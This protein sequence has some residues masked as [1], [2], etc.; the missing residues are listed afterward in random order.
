[1]TS[2]KIQMMHE[3]Y[4]DYVD[5]Q[6]ELGEFNNPSWEEWRKEKYNG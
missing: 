6:E 2:L 5:T 3:E 4:R 1:M